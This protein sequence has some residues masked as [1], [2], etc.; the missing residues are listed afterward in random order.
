MNDRELSEVILFRYEAVCRVQ[1]LV[2]DGETL[3]AACRKVAE[4]LRAAPV[5]HHRPKAK[6]LEVFGRPGTSGAEYRP[7]SEPSARV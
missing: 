3:S 1:A 6:T 2:D 5:E 7:M 4:V